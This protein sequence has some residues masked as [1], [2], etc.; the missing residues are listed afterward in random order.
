MALKL[1]TSATAQPLTLAEAKLQCRVE[2]AFTDDDS[3]ITAYI[4]AATLDA[5]HIMQRAV[6]PQKWQLTLDQ[7]QKSGNWNLAYSVG[8]APHI[9]EGIEL[10]RPPVTGVDS[11]KYIAA[12]TGVLTTLDPSVY[13][14]VAA[15]DYTAMIVPAYAQSWP[16]SRAQPESVQVIFSCGYADAA[17]VPEPIK[18]WIKMR[19][20]ALYKTRESVVIGSRL[21]MLSPP[22]VDGLL[23]RYRVETL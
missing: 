2:T 10:R 21:V 18:Q 5:E 11:V 22:Y 20:A 3:L 8:L 6:M 17:S 4:A 23:D 19:V 9:W 1:Q 14:V 13:Q 16:T 12:D 7:F 15:S